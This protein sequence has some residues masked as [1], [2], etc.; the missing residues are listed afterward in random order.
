MKSVIKKQTHYSL[1]LMR[2]DTEAR[3]YRVHGRV[4]RF[5]IWFFLLFVAVGAAGIAGSVYFW[6]EYRTL[7]KRYEAQE[8]E[9][10]EMKL[11]LERLVTLETVLAASNDNFRRTR[12]IEVGV[13]EAAALPRD[14]TEQGAQAVD[15]EVEQAGEGGAADQP[16]QTANGEATASGNGSQA[17]ELTYPR[18]FSQRSPLRVTGFNSRATGQ[19]RI[20]VRYELVAE[21]NVEQRMINGTIRYFVVFAD[22]TRL[23]PSVSNPAESRFS[24]ARMKL[25]Q[26]TLQLPQGHRAADVQDIDVLIELGDGQRFEERFNAGGHG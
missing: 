8:R 2:D 25:V 15:G 10:S 26:N 17:P 6:E 23:E 22:G 24:I 18:I 9:V 21:G 5:F 16:G 3:S 20:S 11:H 7:A 12:H 19:Q 4:L 1:L 14:A 13:G